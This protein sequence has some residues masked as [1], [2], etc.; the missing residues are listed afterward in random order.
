M[1][2]ITALA[3]AGLLCAVGT[4]SVAIPPNPDAAFPL[5]NTKI[6]GQPNPGTIL[7]LERDIIVNAAQTRKAAK[8][9]CA[10]D[11]SVTTIEQDKPSRL[12]RVSAL[13]LIRCK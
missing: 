7:V 2:K 5:A 10:G 8:E 9:W 12:G 11:A 4:Q 13:W 3:V 1:Q 6:V